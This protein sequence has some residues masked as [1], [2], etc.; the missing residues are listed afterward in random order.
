MF[1]PEL[2]AAARGLIPADTVYRN[3]K[4]FNPFT[5]SWDGGD[6]AVKEGLVIGIGDYRG[7]H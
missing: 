3:S 2:I 5:C 4:I 7:I 1:S 6:L